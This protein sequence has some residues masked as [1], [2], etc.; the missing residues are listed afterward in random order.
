MT[1]NQKDTM[2]FFGFFYKLTAQLI[3]FNIPKMIKFHFL[4]WEAQL[5]FFLVHSKNPIIKV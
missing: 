3:K 5:F 1:L 2:I 4:H